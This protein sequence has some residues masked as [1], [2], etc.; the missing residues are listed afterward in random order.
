VF[1]IQ[2]D[3]AENVA[4]ALEVTLGPGE[5]R[6]LAKQ[7]T[8][9][10]EAYHLYLQ[11]LS[12]SHKL[13]KEALHNSISF[14]E[15]A[16]Q[17][18]PGFAQAYAGIAVAYQE[19]GYTSLLVP[20]EAFEKVR[21]AAEKALEIDDTIVEA[22]MAAAAMAQI[23]DYDQAR[24]G[25]AYKRAVE[26]APNSAATHAYYGIMYLSP[27]GRHEEAIAELRRAVELD[28]V[29]VMYLNKLG[30]VYYMAHR[31][32]PA[33]EYLQRSLELERS[34]VD[35]YRG[36]GEVYVQKGMHD[37]AIAAMQ[38][39]VELTDG[40]DTALGYLGYAYGMAGERDKATEVLERLQDRATR[41]HVLPYAFAPLY[42]GLGEN[43]QAIEALWRDYDERAGSHEMVFLKVFPTYDSLHSDP[44]F[45]DLLRKIGVEPE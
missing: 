7:G 21:A 14:F 16:L 11:G 36:L 43:D 12:L 27:M 33:I 42:V 34:S 30:W 6:Q 26:L 22:H 9:N 13:S 29:S 10:L 35:G 15:R 2:S 18:D 8:Q 25:L 24:A 39:Y 1:A 32:D 38:K 19:L 45:I 23:L 5:K 3:V 20:S 4:A 37:E 28:P 40:Y 31:Y 17:L 41:Q 44:R